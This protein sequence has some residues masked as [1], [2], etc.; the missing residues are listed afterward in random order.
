[1]GG[2]L[3]GVSPMP[4]PSCSTS[5]VINQPSLPPVE[6]GNYRPFHPGSSRHQTSGLLLLLCNYQLI[7][8]MNFLKA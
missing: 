3:E 6:A 1:M 4:L 7:A 2:W 5:G 8:E